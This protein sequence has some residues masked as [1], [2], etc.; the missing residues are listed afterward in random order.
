MTNKFDLVSGFF[1]GILTALAG[2]FL[3]LEIFTDY[4]FLKGIELMR[5]EGYLGKLITV[6][7]VLNLIVFFIL[8]RKDKDMMARGVILATLVL[9]ILTIML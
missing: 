5:T 7:A 2:T 4:G 9:A 8:L 1:I 6:G 3:F